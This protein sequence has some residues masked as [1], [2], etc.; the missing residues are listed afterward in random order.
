MAVAAAD[1]AAALL[2]WQWLQPTLLLRCCDGSGLGRHRFSRWLLP[3][4]TG[5]CNA[6]NGR[7]RGRMRQPANVSRGCDALPTGDLLYASDCGVVLPSLTESVA[8]LP[9]V[10]ENGAALP[11]V[12]VIKSLGVKEHCMA[13]VH[14]G[15]ATPS[16]ALISQAPVSFSYADRRARTR[17][18]RQQPARWRIPAAAA[19]AASLHA[20]TVRL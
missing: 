9:P 15:G 13:S 20:P 17:V 5:S 6:A 19:L 18:L 11:P 3:D 14:P 12:I 4:G 10:M 16:A 1:A 7:L 2:R 8:A